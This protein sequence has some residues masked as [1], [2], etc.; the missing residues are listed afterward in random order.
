MRGSHVDAPK[1]TFRWGLFGWKLWLSLLIAAGVV[2]LS[3]WVFGGDT[4]TT[5]SSLNDAIETESIDYDA[6][7]AAAE[8]ERKSRAQAE[9]SS[10]EQS[11]SASPTLENRQALVNAEMAAGEYAAAADLLSEVESSLTYLEWNQLANAY[12]LAGNKEAAAAAYRKTADMWPQDSPS[13]DM[14]VKYLRLQADVLEG[15]VTNV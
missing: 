9:A 11:F 13:Y 12:E 15:K 2:A 5:D 6:Q 4:S 10:V 1:Y 14:N 3:I 8:A 7:D